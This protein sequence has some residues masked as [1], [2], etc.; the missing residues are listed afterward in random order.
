MKKGKRTPGGVL[1]IAGVLAALVFFTACDT[2]LGGYWE[3]EFNNE[4]SYTITVTLDESYKTS[5]DDDTEVNTAFNLYTKSSY[6]KS[7]RTVYVKSGSVGFEWT[8]N[9]SNNN[10]NIYPEKNGSKVTFK[11]RI[12]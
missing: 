10:R 2:P 7:S 8:A 5:T 9:N 6:S 3:Y 4:T 11:E 12:K 1:C